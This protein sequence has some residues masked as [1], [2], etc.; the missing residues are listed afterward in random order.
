LPRINE[1]F[2]NLNLKR[3][4]VD[5]MDLKF[6]FPPKAFSRLRPLGEFQLLGNFTGFV[7]DFV[8][9]GT[10]NGKFGQ[11][12]SDVNLKINTEDPAL[13]QYKGNIRLSDFKLGTYLTDT[14]ML[15]SVSMTGHIDG[16][17][18]TEASA[19][20]Q[21]NGKISHFKIK[22]YDYK[23]IITN[24]RF[25]SQFF[26]GSLTI[27]DPNL[28]FQAEG[29]ID[30]SKDNE[31]VKMKARLDTALIHNLGFTKDYF[32]LQSVVD[33]DSKGLNIDS[34][35]GNAFLKNTKVTY[36][37][38]SLEI[39]SIQVT[40]SKLTKGRSLLLRS[41]F[42]DVNL[43]GE[44]YYSS[45][46][47]DLNK[48]FKEFYLTI[49]NDRAELNTYYLTKRKESQEYDA[50]FN[51]ILKDINPIIKVVG[52]NSQLSK[53]TRVE[54]KFSNGY[55]SILNAYSTIDSITYDGK[56]FTQNTI[57][58]NGSK[59]RDSTNILAMLNI[60]SANQT[61]SKNFNTKDLFVEA[62][63]NTDHIEV[64]VDFDQTGKD[65]Y[66]RVKAAVDFLS[67]STR[68]KIL[69]SSIKALNETWQVNQ[70]NYTI[71]SGN[72]WRINH[73]AIQNDDQKVLLE[74]FISQDSSKSL[75]LNVNNLDLSFLNS[76]S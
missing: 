72:E 31:L 56:L 44:Y 76:I 66:A 17:G 22:D 8:A 1:T 59:I 46:F 68:I 32:S 13:S 37:G 60:N 64:G 21:L 38:E 2:V 49:K 30:F 47:N 70:E 29:S 16:K 10:F 51:I 52:V 3:S 61:L 14:T 33:I 43:H 9:N 34:I 62:I 12:Q 7:N 54:G 4:N 11:I 67:D 41:S 42:A 25:K 65:N 71:L 58:F 26:N 74:G 50:N 20:F 48:L 57:E 40:S 69:P 45:L 19:D 6:L 39:D 53:N 15:R 28:K 27:N 75:S 55:T 73:L 63:W 18:F 35:F 23:N 24:A 36:R 5:I